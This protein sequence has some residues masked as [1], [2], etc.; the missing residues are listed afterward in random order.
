MSPSARALIV[1]GARRR[2]EARVFDIEYA[3]A[4][5]SGRDCGLAI[6]GIAGR[7]Y[8]RLPTENSLA[9]TTCSFVK[10][11]MINRFRSSVSER[12]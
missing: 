10:S 11:D 9:L 1:E 7:V 2:T 8:F 5:T 3:D 6:T 4:S 12:L